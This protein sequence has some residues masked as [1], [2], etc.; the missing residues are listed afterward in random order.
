VKL[1]FLLFLLSI[2]VS[3]Q[4]LKDPTAR[5][6]VSEGLNKSYNF[7][8]N[9]AEEFYLKINAKY[10]NNPA[11]H[12]LMQMMLYT[13]F[14]PVKDNPKM[15]NLY[16][17]HLNKSLELAEK[18]IDKNENDTEGIFFMVSSL[19]SLSAWQADNDEML[20][21]VNTARRAFPYMKKGMKLTEVQPDFLFTTGLYNYYIEQYPEDHPLV[22][23]FMIFFSD[24]NKKLGLQQLE[25]C[26]NK[27]I[28]TYAEAAYYAAYIYGKHENRHDKALPIISK[29][30]ERYPE[31]ILYKAKKAECLVT[32]NKIESAKPIVEDLLKVSGRVYP[33]IGHTLQAII[34]E[35]ANKNDKL[36]IIEYRKVLKIP[37]DVRYTQDYHAMAYLGLGRIAIREKQNNQAKLYLKK[38]IELSQYKSVLAEAKSLLKKLP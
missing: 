9:E 13:K 34:E 5:G 26:S 14:A 21:A 37:L 28:F 19:G 15:R 17:Y 8:F 1:I 33:I 31:N 27:A 20:K 12:T 16:L 32:L 36:A 38:C 24:G 6:W 23:P 11:Y 29:L 4:L 30:S 7:Q 25:N 2:K 3:G 18:M 22:K 10:P 35:K